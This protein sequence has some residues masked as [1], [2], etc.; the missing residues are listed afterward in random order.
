MGPFGT[1]YAMHE[2]VHPRE[3]K[4][5]SRDI[6]AIARTDAEYVIDLRRSRYQRARTA[7]TEGFRRRSL[8]QGTG[9]SSQISSREDPGIRVGFGIQACRKL[10][11]SILPGRVGR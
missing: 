1:L 2:R 3:R 6:D 5:C 7:C 11:H 9:I 10:G 4:V 8:K